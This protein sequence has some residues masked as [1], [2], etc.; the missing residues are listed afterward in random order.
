MRAVKR[1]MAAV[2]VPLCLTFPVLAPAQHEG[3]LLVGRSGDGKLVLDTVN[4][5]DPRTELVVLPEIEPTP[6]VSGWSL[7]DPGWDH[8]LTDDPPP[9]V[10]RLDVGAAV[11]AYIAGMDPGFRIGLSLFDWRAEPLSERDRWIWLGDH[12]LHEHY[13]WNIYIEDLCFTCFEPAPPPECATDPPDV[14]CHQ[15][16]VWVSTLLLKDAGT[17]QYDDS[18]P[19]TLM[20]TNDPDFVLKPGDIDLDGWVTLGDFATFA[21]CYGLPVPPPPSE[22]LLL[23]ATRSDLDRNGQVNLSDFA[24]FAVNYGT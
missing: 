1:A 18:D 23:D 11:Y 17:T 16:K 2:A 7:D 12:E 13:D 5:H 15:K 4:G 9:D 3:D 21:V 22:C 8:V 24:T 10:Y 19:F 20:F 14:D 6:L